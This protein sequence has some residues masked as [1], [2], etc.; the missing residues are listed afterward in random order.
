MA[1]KCIQC[2]L[3]NDDSSIQ[4]VC[5]R[6]LLESAPATEAAVPAAPKADPTYLWRRMVFAIWALGFGGLFALLRGHLGA[7][8][9]QRCLIGAAVFWVTAVAALFLL[10]RDQRRSLNVW[11]IVFTVFSLLPMPLL[12]TIVDGIAEQGWPSGRMNRIA[13]EMLTLVLTVALPVFIT[14]VCALVRLRLVTGILAAAAGANSIITGVLL[15]RATAP[16]KN[17]A[18]PLTD[19]LDIVVVGARLL[20]FL[21][22]PMGIA[23]IAGG[24]L[25]FWAAWKTRRA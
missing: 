16:V 10:G 9:L 17:L 14:G 7:A 12:L 18:R 11:R 15:F 21:A 13:A 22:V 20:S 5:G 19:I 4:C 24:I 23:L 6:D 8:P 2:G 1:K 3:D 25:T